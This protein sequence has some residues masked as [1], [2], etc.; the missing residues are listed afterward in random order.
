[1]KIFLAKCAGNFVDLIMLEAI[2]QKRVPELAES[3]VGDDAGTS[4]TA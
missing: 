4:L 2:A 1:M 3:T